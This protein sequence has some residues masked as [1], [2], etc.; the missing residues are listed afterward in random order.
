MHT[1]LNLVESYGSAFRDLINA[2]VQPTKLAI[3]EVLKLNKDEDWAFLCSAMDIIGDAC[4]AIDNFLKYGLDGPTK[5]NE[6][7]ERYLRLYG[8]LSATY[9]QQQAVLKL[10]QLINA[11]PT[12]KAGKDMIEALEI[13]HLRHKLSSHN[14]NY[15]D[16]KTGS[17]ETYVPIRVDLRGFNCGYV[18]NE[19]VKVYSVDLQKAINEHLDTLIEM[20][21]KILEKAI[22]TFYN[23]QETSEGCKVFTEKL[24]ELRII[25]KGGLVARLPDGAKL[26]MTMAKSD[27]AI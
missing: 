9:I 8:I 12:L 7:G 6:A 4:L 26:I 18:N 22:K 16:T 2:K 1:K 20:Q 11:P 3:R 19:D 14:T 23:G 13:R 27:E 25:R 15:K 21:D 17:I 5:Y 10:Y 24:E